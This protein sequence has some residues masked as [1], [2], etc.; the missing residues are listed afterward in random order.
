MRYAMNWIYQLA[1]QNIGLKLISLVA[2]FILWVL[3]ASDP[4]TEA[5]FRVPV[6]FVNVPSQ[7]EV[8]TDQPSVRLWARGPSRAIRRASASDFAVRVDVGNATSQNKSTYS[9]GF[10]DVSAP[11]P[12]EVKE[13]IPDEITISL[14]QTVSK[15]VPI[16]PRFFGE[17]RQGYRLGGIEISPAVAKISGPSSHLDAVTAVSSVLLDLSKVSPG[18]TITAG[19]A[20]SDPRIRFIQP[21]SIQ[22]KVQLEKVDIPAPG[23]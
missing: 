1:T 20:I 4:I 10:N 9:L 14:D 2:A 19:V 13:L 7:L 12:L 18:E 5:S 6:E 23:R 8:L 22:I 15:E 21:Q 11:S 16:H 3:I 17:P